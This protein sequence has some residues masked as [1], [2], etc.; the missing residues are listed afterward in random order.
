MAPPQ[1]H[2]LFGDFDPTDYEAEAQAR[3]PTIYSEARRRTARYGPD[4]WRQAAAESD[5]IRG[6]FGEL[7]RSGEPAEGPGAA[8]LA[9]RHRLSI[10]RWYY[11]CSKTQHMGLGQLY[12]ADARFAEYWDGTAPGL[13]KYVHDA[14]VANGRVG[15]VT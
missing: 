1:P 11:P 2:D 9:E 15:G 14:I 10:D 12:V 7:M 3:W 4:E 13:A 8:E 6:E 5:A